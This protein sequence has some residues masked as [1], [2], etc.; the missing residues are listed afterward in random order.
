MRSDSSITAFKYC[1]FSALLKVMSWSDVKAVR[2]SL[3]SRSMTDGVLH[4]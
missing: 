1:K 4:K 3:T 2:I